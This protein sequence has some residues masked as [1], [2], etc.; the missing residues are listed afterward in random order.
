MKG[1]TCPCYSDIV[2]PGP[3]FAQLQHGPS[4]VVLTRGV[5]E[6]DDL[7]ASSAPGHAGAGLT[8]SVCFLENEIVAGGYL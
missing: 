4:E 1:V 2:L 7:T 6:S 5:L 8:C 3:Q